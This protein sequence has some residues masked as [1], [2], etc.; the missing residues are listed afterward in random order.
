MKFIFLDVDGVLNCRTTTDI[1][2]DSDGRRWDGIDIDKMELLK[3]ILDETGANII[4]SSTWRLHP[5]FLEYLEKKLGIYN[6]RIKGYTPTAYR[7]LGS[8]SER[9]DEIKKWFE[10][11]EKPENYIILDDIDYKMKEYFGDHYF[12]TNVDI[13]LTREIADKCIEYLNKE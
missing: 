1:F 9:W 8:Y 11:N 4:V 10:E 13:G 12:Q 5:E 2:K 7:R 6:R 3:E